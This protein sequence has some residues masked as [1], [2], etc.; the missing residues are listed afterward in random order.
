MESILRFQ[1]IPDVLNM[2]ALDLILIATK[3]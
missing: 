2:T 1:F 3:S